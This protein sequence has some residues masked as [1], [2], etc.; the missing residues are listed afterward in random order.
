M[1]GGAGARGAQQ[2]PRDSSA[3]PAGL[4][5]GAGLGIAA[6]L[7]PPGCG[8]VKLSARVELFSP[9]LISIALCVRIFQVKKC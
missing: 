6:S 1:A 2:R 3:K 5:R 9:L 4:R 7:P 8:D